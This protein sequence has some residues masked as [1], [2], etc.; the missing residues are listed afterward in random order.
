MENIR[1]TQQIL[2]FHKIFFFLHKLIQIKIQQAKTY[3]SQKVLIHLHRYNEAI[4]YTYEFLSFY[5]L[6]QLTSDFYLLN[7]FLLRLFLTLYH[8]LLQNSYYKVGN[9]AQSEP[10]LMHI[11]IELILLCWRMLMTFEY[12]SCL[13]KISV[14]FNVRCHYKSLVLTKFIQKDQF[15]LHFLADISASIFFS[16]VKMEIL[17]IY[18]SGVE[19]E[20]KNRFR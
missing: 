13:P 10:E 11:Y 7:S 14:V 4:D 5:S 15:W 12:I 1:F 18:P 17:F 6:A 3:Q 9:V 16:N 2:I 20:I 19:K 8:L